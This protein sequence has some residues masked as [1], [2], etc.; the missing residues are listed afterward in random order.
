MQGT[1]R[2]ADNERWAEKDRRLVWHQMAG[3]PAGPDAPGPLLLVE[4]DGAWVT[5]VEGRRYLDGMSGQWCVNAGYGRL[6]LAGAAADQ[7]SKLA[8]YPL[9]RGHLPAIELGERLDDLLGGG[10][11]FVY[12]N[13]GSE[14][15]EVAFKLVRQYHQLNGEPH[16]FKIISRYRAYHGSTAAALAASGQSLRRLSYESLPPG[17]VHVL[18]PDPLR[19]PEGTDLEEYGRRCAAE[20]EQTI[21]L[22][23]PE[24]VAAVIMEPI[25]TGGGVL[26]PP[27][28]YMPAVAEACRRHGVLF[29][30]DE[31]ICGFGRT[32]RWFGHEHAGVRP[33]VVTM[34]KGITSAYFPLAAAA[35]SDEIFA[36]FSGDADTARLRHMNTF[37]GHPAGCAVALRNI[38]ILEEEGL[39]GRSA[40]LGA[41]LLGRLREALGDHPMV[42]EVRGR[43]LLVGIEVVSDRETN[44]PAARADA[45]ALVGAAQRRGLLVGRNADTAGGMDNVVV[46]APPLCATEDDLDHIVRVLAEVFAEKTAPARAGP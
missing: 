42:G 36:A 11:V 45:V 18:P 26:I 32:G 29:I 46:L 8:F 19:Q 28:S 10:R 6:E 40:E 25:I 9:T 27:D 12:A 16:R 14:A 35:V 43:G 4:G 2:H 7:L 44:A 33:D 30:V 41:D 15:N 17:F 31:V 37:G 23:L 3:R 39:V 22:E 21:T 20:L 34:A 24:T 1:A 38:A 13:S 5:D